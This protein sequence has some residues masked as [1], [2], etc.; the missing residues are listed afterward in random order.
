MIKKI[1][2]FLCTLFLL[3]TPLNTFALSGSY[4]ISSSS[5]VEVGDTISVKFTIKASKMFYWQAYITY[6]N[7]HLQ[8]VSGST[9]FQGES[10][11]INGQGSVSKTLKFKAKKTGS[12]WVA[13]AMGSSGYNINNN[14]E[15]ISF[16]KK[17]KTINIKEKTVKTYSSNNNLSSLSV[18]QYQIS[19]SFNKN[20]TEYTVDLPANTE[21]IKITAKAEDKNASVSG[22]GEVTVSEGKNKITIKVKAENGNIKEYI[23][24][25]SVKELEPIDVNIDNK[26]YTVIRK[27][28]QLPKV[29]ATYTDTTVEIN[30]QQVP[31]LFSEITKYT[32][33]GLKDES[34]NI[35][36]YVYDK[37]KNSYTVYQE[38]GFNKL[39]IVPVKAINIPKNYKETTI[40]IDN[41]NIVA[42][43]NKSQFPIFYGMNIESGKTDW[44]SYDKEENTIQRFSTD[45]NNTTKS[46]TNSDIDIYLYAIIL[47][48]G[49]L[50]ITYL[51]ILINLLKKKTKPKKIELNYKKEI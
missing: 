47:L 17:S 13:I 19:P 51:I 32:L 44:Y 45:S 34:G 42:Y 40:T 26:K 25:A 15:S 37:D 6:D 22:D 29:S 9:T 46:N 7:S 10:D 14:S 31:A 8:L 11:S 5:S 4:D 2:L 48:G 27:K 49:V 12:S 1:C 43:E 28:D 23:L 24:N 36:L 50:V 16:S 30:S 33:V 18:D 21:K 39:T 35:N 38:F 41:Q 20:T 3:L